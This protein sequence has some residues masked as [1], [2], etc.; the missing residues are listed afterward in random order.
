[1]LAEL[2]HLVKHVRNEVRFRKARAQQRALGIRSVLEG[3]ERAAPS[4]KINQ[5]FGLPPVVGAA[6]ARCSHLGV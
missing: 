3:L 4:E 5:R 1:V 6:V 2:Q